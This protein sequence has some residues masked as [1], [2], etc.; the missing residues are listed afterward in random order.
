[1][2]HNYDSLSMSTTGAPFMRGDY[3]LYDIEGYKDSI[4]SI[5]TYS[6]EITLLLIHNDI[7]NRY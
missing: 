5:R 3:T 4:H 2:S 1:M 7:L 6:N